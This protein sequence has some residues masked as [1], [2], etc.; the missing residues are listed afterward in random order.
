MS[1]KS[2][3]PPESRPAIANPVSSTLFAAE[4]VDAQTPVVPFLAE[5]ASQPRLPTDLVMAEMVDEWSTLPPAQSWPVKAWRLLCFTLAWLFGLASL[6][7]CLA[8]V[9]VV[10]LLQFA[11]LGYLL[12]A[13]GRVTRSGKL[14]DGFIDIRR[15][16]RIGSLVAGT[17]IM[18]LPIRFIAG[19]TRD[20]EAIP[21]NPAAPVWRIALTICTVLMVGHILLAWYSGGKLRHFFW[22]LL[23]PFQLGQRLLNSGLVAPA[24]RRLLKPWWPTLYEDL[25]TPLP[26]TSWFPPAILWAGLWRGRMYVEARDAV[27]DFVVGL[28]LPH[29]F[30]LGLRGFIGAL[31]WLAIPIT[32]LTAGT[33]QPKPVAILVGWAGA[34][35]LAAVLLY[36]PFLQ[37]HF[38]AENRFSAMFAWREVRQQFRRAP[39]I[40]WFSLLATLAFALPLYLLKI[41]PP[42]RPLLWTLSVFFILFIY[43]ARLFTGWAL[44]YARR[45]EK[46]S[47]FILRLCSRFAAIPV[48]LLFV[49]IVFFTQYTSWNGV[50]SLFEQHA[51]LVPVPF[52]GM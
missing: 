23:A 9:S 44:G 10:P 48:V 43:P 12:E 27:W 2:P 3:L 45:R 42:P 50:A 7:G 34:L 29:Y 1:I 35:L 16:A 31:L 24:M 15:F 22:P 39:L 46:P 38:A 14:R 30:W 13:S 26:W 28:Q 4:A 52:L 25:F 5:D 19:L 33:A 37:A 41:E 47:W 36:L 18:L 6:I 32:M 8:A 11:S 49:L 21:G 40:F 17:W 51:F 20:A